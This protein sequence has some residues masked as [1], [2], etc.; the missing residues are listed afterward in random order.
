MFRCKVCQSARLGNMARITKMTS[1]PKNAYIHKNCGYV[2]PKNDAV[3][4]GWDAE[5]SSTHVHCPRCG[6]IVYEK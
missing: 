3:V 5:H 4:S 2:L 6:K 1:S